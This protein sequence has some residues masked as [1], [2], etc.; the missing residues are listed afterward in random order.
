MRSWFYAQTCV[1]TSITHRDRSRDPH[2]Q[3][4]VFAPR[5]HF[6]P[7]RAPVDRVHFVRMAWELVLDLL[8]LQVPD[9]QRTILARG[10]KQTAIRA[11]CAHV[12]VLHMA[13]KTS[14]ELARPP[15]PQPHRV[16]EAC[17]RDILAVRRKRN[18]VHRL[19]VTRHSDD[20]LLVADGV[21]EEHREVVRARAQQLVLQPVVLEH[22]FHLGLGRLHPLL[23]VSWSRALVVV[24]P[25]PQ[26]VVHVQ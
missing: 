17:A 16:V 14:D 5:R 1:C 13:K 3:H 26:R 15:V 10:Q 18:V 7:V 6:L 11:P 8:R 2:F 20:R 23:L 25:Y 21:P 4:F 22:L 24:R 19:L 9:H 12:D